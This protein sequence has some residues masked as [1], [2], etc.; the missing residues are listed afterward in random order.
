MAAVSAYFTCW[1]ISSA[2]Q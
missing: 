2:F 1:K